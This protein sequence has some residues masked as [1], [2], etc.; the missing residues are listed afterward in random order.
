MGE[1]IRRAGVTSLPEALR[2]V[3]GLQ[4]SQID[5][6]KWSIT[7]RGFAGRFANKLQVLVD[8]RIV[9]SP[10][11]SGVF[12]EQQD[13]VLEDIDRIEVIRGPAA[14][15]YGANAVNGTINI[16]TKPAAET[17]GA[18]VSTLTSGDE[19]I[20]STRYGGA[21]GELGHARISGKLR[22]TDARERDGRPADDDV[23]LGRVDVRSDL[24]VGDGDSLTLI[25]EVS[26]LN[27]GSTYEVPSLI[28][29]F[30]RTGPADADLYG[31]EVQAIWQRRFSGQSQLTVQ[32]Y[33]QYG[34]LELRDN[35]GD[36][37]LFN[38]T[39]KIFDLSA[40][41]GVPIG[42]SHQVVAGF[43]YRNVSVSTDPTPFFVFNDSKASNDIAS[44]FLQDEI[45]LVPAELTLTLASRFDYNSL[46]GAEVQPTARLLWTPAPEVSIWGAASRAVRATSTGIA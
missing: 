25:G 37:G 20:A 28:S 10:G 9:Y 46:N 40:E 13:F 8:G 41:Y 21:L 17:Q 45:T 14:A 39:G 11:F 7:S 26:H 31:G 22:R 19:V 16:I 3:P 15:L 35:V 34:D 44:V 23:A 12:W 1:D 27:A 30:Q 32:G 18:F 4:V 24:R 29:P 43:E 2:L 38:G 36:Q 33:F 42:D 5:N 6:S